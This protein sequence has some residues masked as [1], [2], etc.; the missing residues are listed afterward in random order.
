MTATPVPS[1]SP[2]VTSGSAVASSEPNTMNRTIAGGEDPER[3]AARTLLARRLGDLSLDLD[4]DAVA[5]G[6]RAPR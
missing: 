5:R 4:L 1:D 3:E 6:R 2:A